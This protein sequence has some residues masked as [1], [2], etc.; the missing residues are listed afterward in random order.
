MDHPWA[1]LVERISDDFATLFWFSSL[2]VEYDD[3][4]VVDQPYS[5]ATS[6]NGG[7]VEL[8]TEG[9]PPAAWSEEQDARLLAADWNPPEADFPYWSRSCATPHEVAHHLVEG[10]VLAFGCQDPSRFT[11][12]ATLHRSLLRDAADLAPSAADVE[13]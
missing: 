6:V 8:H 1:T 7:F 11:W 3:G 10:L 13:K 5:R 12:R 2:T 9:D 4:T